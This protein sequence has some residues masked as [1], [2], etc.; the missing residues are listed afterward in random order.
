MSTCL[1]CGRALRNHLRRVRRA[2]R[3]GVILH[4]LAV[5]RALAIW[6]KKHATGM[7]RSHR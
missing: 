5:R 4:M 2:Q 1:G 7:F 6:R 3:Y